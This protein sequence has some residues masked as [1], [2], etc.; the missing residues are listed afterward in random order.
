[1]THQRVFVSLALWSILALGNAVRVS[2]TSLDDLHA[3]AKAPNSMQRY[4]G[5]TASKICGGEDTDIDWTLIMDS[6]DTCACECDAAQCLKTTCSGEGYD[7]ERNAAGVLECVRVETTGGEVIAGTAEEVICA[8]GELRTKGGSAEC[9]MP[10]TCPPPP[11]VGGRTIELSGKVGCE[12]CRY[13]VQ[14]VDPATLVVKGG[15]A[16]CKMPARTTEVNIKRLTKPA[17]KSCPS[18]GS[19]L[20][21]GVCLVSPVDCPGVVVIPPEALACGPKTDDYIQRMLLEIASEQKHIS[22]PSKLRLS[23]VA[24]CH[25]IF[26]KFTECAGQ[27]PKQCVGRA[28]GSGK[29]IGAV[30]NFAKHNSSSWLRLDPSKASQLPCKDMYGSEYNFKN[31]WVEG[32][33]KLEALATGQYLLLQGEYVQQPM[34]RLDCRKSLCSKVDNYAAQQP[35]GTSDRSV[36]QCLDQCAAQYK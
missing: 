18:G 3:F 1:M 27:S 10:A 24:S 9:V 29:A 35:Q 23:C 4:R 8:P 17:E 13:P 32:V 28:A 34:G 30:G 31:G 36:G 20:V 7:L 12:E 16:F 2:L 21:G 5:P 14:C 25:A 11:T 33:A 6:D 26:A 22:N 19:P 15:K